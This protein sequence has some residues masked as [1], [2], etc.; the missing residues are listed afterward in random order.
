[1]TIHRKLSG[2]ISVLLIGLWASAG[3]RSDRSNEQ[4]PQQS[5]DQV[6]VPKETRH[7]EV[8]EASWY[9][10]GFHGQET[11]SGETC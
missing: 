1:M 10:P 4:N 9:G 8:G 11:A 3:C 6:S 2:F 5:P 7:K